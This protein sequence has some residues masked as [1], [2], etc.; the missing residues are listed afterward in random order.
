MERVWAGVDIGK[1]HH[2]V[3]V[4]DADGARMLSRRVANDEPTLLDLLGQVTALAERVHWA[5]DLSTGGAA[6]LL[7]LLVA[8][9]QQ[10]FYLSGN[11]VSR[12]AGGYRGEGKTDAKDAAIIADQVRMRRDLAPMRVDDELIVE[13]RM[14]VA[15]RRDLAGDR[16]RLVNRL[17]EHLL[18]IS[19]ALERV[20]NLTNRGPLVLLTH[21]QTPAAIRQ[22][23][24]AGLEQWLRSQKVRGAA[25]LAATV[26]AAANS[27]RTTLPGEQLA[28]QLVADMAKGVMSLDE[29]IA[30]TDTLIEG[31]FHRHRHAAALLSMPGIGVLLGAEFLAATGGDMAAFTSADHLAGYAGLAPAPR[32]SGRISGNLHR[33]RRY[34]RGLQRVFYTSA[35]V[36]I[37]YNDQSRTFYDRKRSE[38]KRHTQAVLALA[39]RRVNV[40][41]ALLRDNRCYQPAPPPLIAAAA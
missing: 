35:L 36:S 4:I 17:H 12:A 16:V 23:G 31:R 28:A 19:P 38:G 10:V 6:L 14:L 32:D 40:I 7:G 11:Q 3:V 18:G 15:R 9:G 41:W 21:V 22:L 5:V 33:P 30:Q 8:H 24:P 1:E 20:L 39:R 27:Q 25:A 37:R 29:Q 2:H 13:L 34:H 26:T